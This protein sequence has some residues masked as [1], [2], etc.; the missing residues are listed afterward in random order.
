MRM[1]CAG[2]TAADAV[3]RLSE[4]ALAD[5][6]FFLGE[7]SAARRIARALVQERA[8]A[9][10]LTTRQL[11]DT[12][13]RAVGGRRG[14][15]I[16]PATQSFQALRMLVNNELEELAHGLG[17]AERLLRPG[18]RLVVVSF[19][20]LEDR[21]VKTFLA[22]RS[23]ARDGGSRHMPEGPAGPPPTFQTPVRKGVGPSEEE[24]RANP[25]ARSAHMRWAIRTAT[26]V[27]GRFAPPG[28]A[29][30]AVREWE[31]LA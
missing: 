11:A 27:P 1:S 2:P 26:P 17:A 29:V 20:S 23:G 6:L 13:E 24:T 7:D 16:H 25:R 9:P 19:H 14:A 8:R 12:I 10:I 21:L 4:S 28:L 30:S 31:S 18:G 22:E 3:N 15:K 5:I